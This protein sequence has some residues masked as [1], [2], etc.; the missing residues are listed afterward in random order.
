MDRRGYLKVDI[1]KRCRLWRAFVV[2]MRMEGVVRRASFELGEPISVWPERLRLFEA[3]EPSVGF[4]AALVSAGA[5]RFFSWT[6]F[7]RILSFD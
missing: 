6:Y 3:S 7:V 2:S 5:P 1:A 4:A